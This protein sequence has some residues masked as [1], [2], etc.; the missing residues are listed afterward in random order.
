MRTISPINPDSVAR[1]LGLATLE[2]RGETVLPN[3]SILRRLNGYYVSLRG[4][5]MRVNFMP[6][7]ALIQQWVLNVAPIFVALEQAAS[8][9]I[10]FGV[11]YHDGVYTFDLTAHIGDLGDAMSLGR[12]QG[13]THI[14]DCANGI[15]IPVSSPE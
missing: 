15:S 4:A 9:Q 8:Y 1:N 6:Y 5:E 14:F 7:Y 10:Y 11:W 13:Q 12:S 2:D 3:G